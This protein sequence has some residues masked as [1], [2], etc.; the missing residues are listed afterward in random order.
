MGAEPARTRPVTEG[1][2]H[3]PACGKPSGGRARRLA[4][5]GSAAVS[6]RGNRFFGLARRVPGRRPLAD[7]DERE[8]A[9]HDED[10][11]QGA[12][13]QERRDRG[14]R[15]QEPGLEQEPGKAA[16][17]HAPILR[18]R[19]ALRPPAGWRGRACTPRSPRTAS[20]RRRPGAGRRLSLGASTVLSP[21]AGSGS[22]SAGAGGGGI[23]GPDRPG[24]RPPDG[25]LDQRDEQPPAGEQR[26]DHG[27]SEVG[28]AR[29]RPRAGSGTRP[30]SRIS[31][32]I[33]PASTTAE[34]PQDSRRGS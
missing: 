4:G 34:S 32:R 29:P 28:D 10:D 19:P 5:S 16:R 6:P 23:D 25:E 9:G 18:V 27:R 17:E 20:T 14:D 24:L 3:S 33:R 11:R 2:R 13:V 21:A 12:E 26:D 8:G 22:A 1:R 30:R 7:D 31:A 15:D